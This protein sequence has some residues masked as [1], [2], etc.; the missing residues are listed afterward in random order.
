[1]TDREREL[2][3]EREKERERERERDEER[4]GERERKRE[5]VTCNAYLMPLTRTSTFPS[6][7]YCVVSHVVC[8]FDAIDGRR[9]ERKNVEQFKLRCRPV[10]SRMKQ[11]NYICVFR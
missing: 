1:M 2:E 9:K 10:I 4:V 11:K 3:R 5:I 7:G 6:Q 8:L